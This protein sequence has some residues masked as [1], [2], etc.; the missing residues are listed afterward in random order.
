[1]AAPEVPGILLFE[2]VLFIAL[3]GVGPAK[4]HHCWTDLR[5]NPGKSTRPVQHLIRRLH[6]TLNA[7]L[8]R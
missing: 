3:P 8:K 4:M 2:V 5:G 7:A 6:N 1:M